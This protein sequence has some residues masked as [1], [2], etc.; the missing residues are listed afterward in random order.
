MAKSALRSITFGATARSIIFGA[1]ASFGS[2]LL[3]LCSIE[4]AWAGEAKDLFYQ[5]LGT[6]STQAVNTGMSYWIELRR[7]GKLLKVD[8][9]YKFRTGDRIRFHVT[10]NIDGHAHVVMIGGSSGAKLVLF[11]V[12]G[13]DPSNAVRRGKEYVLPPSTFIVFDATKGIERVRIA[14]SRN[15]IAST[16]FLSKTPPNQLAM[17]TISSNPAVDP[18]AGNNQLIVGFPEENKQSSQPAPVQAAAPADTTTDAIPNEMEEEEEESL[19]KDLF[20]EDSAP[21]RRKRRRPAVA[22]APAKPNAAAQVWH[23]MPPRR[24]PVK[25]PPAAAG[26]AAAAAATPPPVTIVVNSNPS[27]DLYADIALEHN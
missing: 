2:F 9:R 12:P 11:P 7:A 16:A 4:P 10:P 21:R 23:A 19:S 15:N 20:R 5:Q 13:K 3:A 26:V 1:T 14:I 8:S 27:E 6:A 24:P 18:S 25:R 22:A 17:A